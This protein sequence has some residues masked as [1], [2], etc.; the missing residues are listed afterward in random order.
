MDVIEG[1][2]GSA[3]DEIFARIVNPLLWD[4]SYQSGFF[5]GLATAGA[6]AII[7]FIFDTFA[8]L[9][10][11]ILQFFKATKGPS[12]P[13]KGPSPFAMFM[14]FLLSL[15]CVIAAIV[16]LIMM[17]IAAIQRTISVPQ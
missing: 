14:K 12:E 16:I 10:D 4:P 9:W 1:I 17:M 7:K 5:W 3:V 2:F 11:R 13:S 6:L 15:V 8:Y